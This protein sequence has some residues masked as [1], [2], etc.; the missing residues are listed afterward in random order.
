VERNPDRLAETLE[1]VGER[2]TFLILRDLWI[3]GPRKFGQLQRNVSVA[4]NI[5]SNRLR[6]LVEGGIVDRRLYQSGPE[7]YEYLLTAVGQELVPA[8]LNVL[9][10]GDR[11]LSGDAGPPMLFRHRD[12]DHVADPVTVCRD[13]GQELTSKSVLAEPPE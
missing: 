2:W 13:C 12:H 3:R 1:L 7:R 10:W 9:V 5:L 6:K 11:H 4:R 8:L